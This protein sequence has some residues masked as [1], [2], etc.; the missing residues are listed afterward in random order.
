MSLWEATCPLTVW[1][2]SLDSVVGGVELLYGSD[3]VRSVYFAPLHQVV[4][5]PPTT[6]DI[7]KRKSF[8]FITMSKFHIQGI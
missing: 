2:F 3:I 5:S 4:F 1:C 6:S 7:L 8:L